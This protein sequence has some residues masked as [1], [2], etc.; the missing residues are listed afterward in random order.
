MAATEEMRSLAA[1][2]KEKAA[3]RKEKAALRAQLADAEAGWRLAA[4]R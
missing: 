4:R 3:L 1:L 2:R